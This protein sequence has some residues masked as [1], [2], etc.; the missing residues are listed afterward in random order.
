MTS[1]TS[2]VGADILA[3]LGIEAENPGGFGGSWIRGMG[4]GSGFFSGSL[5]SRGLRPGGLRS[6][7]GGMGRFRRSVALP[8]RSP[9]GT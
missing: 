9:A 7:G 4:I 3:E 5:S 6:S 8:D 1:A 2:T